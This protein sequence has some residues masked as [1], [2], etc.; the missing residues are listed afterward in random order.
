MQHYRWLIFVIALLSVS[1]CS[2]QVARGKAV[3]MLLD[4][5]GSYG[6]NSGKA[7]DVIKYLLVSLQPGDS[8]ALARI[9]SESF[10]EQDIIAKVSFDSRPSRA[11]AQ[12]RAFFEAS[13]TL[14]ASQ[15]RSSTH[16][17][18]TGGLLQAIEYLNETGA[19]Q[20]TILL[21]SDLKEELRQGQ[22]RDFPINFNGIRV[23][24]L[25]VT[26]LRSDM[27]DPR[28]Y[29]ARLEHW[30]RRIVEGGGYWR[31]I[32]DPERLDTLLN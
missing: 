21:F 6:E 29:T 1:S 26:K 17:D 23:V 8:L 10:S 7:Q 15:P 28:E 13:Q 16:T 24:A 27:A 20:K 14:L 3:Y 12:K 18:I 31:V 22:I 5:S 19:G 4:M 11:N 30:Q 2:D 9:D 25:N 32:N